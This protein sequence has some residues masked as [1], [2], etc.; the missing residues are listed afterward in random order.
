M[1]SMPSE[2]VL[3]S[4]MGEIEKNGVKRLKLRALL[5]SFGAQRRGVDI[6]RRMNAWARDNG[7]VLN[8]L[9]DAKSADDVISVATVIIRRIGRLVERESDLM[10]RFEEEI[11]PKLGLKEPRAHFSPGGSRDRFDY[12]CTDPSG[13]P[14]VVEMKRQDGERRVVEQTLRYIRALRLD[15]HFSGTDPRGLIITG[16]ADIPTRRALEE[17]EPAY[18]I[19]WWLYGLGDDGDLRLER[20]RI[21]GGATV[22]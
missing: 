4:W 3:S 1:P 11:A 7:V 20:E 16:E 15:R 22:R 12:L 19:D 18:T 13:R 8:G 6:L 9:E 17:L 2:R 5:A 10:D 14:V 21:S